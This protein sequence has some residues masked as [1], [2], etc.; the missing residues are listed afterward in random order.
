VEGLAALRCPYAFFKGVI[1]TFRT[2]WYR[3]PR[4]REMSPRGMP[5]ESRKRTFEA[6]DVSASSLAWM[7]LSR[8]GA[9]FFVDACVMIFCPFLLYVRIIAS[10]LNHYIP[11]YRSNQPPIW[12][13][14]KIYFAGLLRAE[15]L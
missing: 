10:V 14:V 4:T 8:T 7:S 3:I 11:S 2:H 6:V 9:D 13:D 5:V 15:G 1:R 12:G